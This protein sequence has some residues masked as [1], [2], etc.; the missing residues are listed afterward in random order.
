MENLGSNPAEPG[1]LQSEE[2][3]PM[4]AVPG[5][6]KVVAVA[7]QLGIHLSLDEAVKYRKCLVAQMG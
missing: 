4:S 1:S 3:S 2:K 6:D 5:V 7:K